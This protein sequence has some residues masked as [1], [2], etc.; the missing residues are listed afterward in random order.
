VARGA[1]SAV[2]VGVRYVLEASP[3]SAGVLGK[4]DPSH[5]RRTGGEGSR[6]AEENPGE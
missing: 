6:G 3:M 1:W 5:G 2:A 4:S